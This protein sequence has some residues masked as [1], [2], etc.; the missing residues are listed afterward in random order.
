MKRERESRFCYTIGC[1]GRDTAGFLKALKARGVS[2]VVDIRRWS[3]PHWTPDYCIANLGKILQK[4]VIFYLSARHL[5]PLADLL[6]RHQETPDWE[7]F[8]AEYTKYLRN[9]SYAQQEIKYLIS[10][11]RSDT[12]ITLL[13]GCKDAER[14]HRSILAGEITRAAADITFTEVPL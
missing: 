12:T 13:C 14:C 1:N 4:N 3:D 10:M 2:V 6:V 8:T 5:P 11:V 9:T 7:R